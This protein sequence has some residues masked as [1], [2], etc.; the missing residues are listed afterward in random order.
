MLSN[1]PVIGRRVVHADARPR[2]AA[3]QTVKRHAGGLAEEV[4]LCH[5]DRAENPHVGAARAAHRHIEV[6]S[7]PQAIDVPRIAAEELARVILERADLSLIPRVSFA[8][9]DQARIRV[10]LDPAPLGALLAAAG[11]A[12]DLEVFAKGHGIDAGDLHRLGCIRRRLHRRRRFARCPAAATEPSPSCLRNV[13]R[14]V[15]LVCASSYVCNEMPAGLAQLR[16]GLYIERFGV[17]RRG[18][19]GEVVGA[20]GLEPRTFWV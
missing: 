13:L 8:G 2:L 4:H 17:L 19:R 7:A 9:A 6:E 16:L 5:V 18:G 20:R 11:P 12:A 14:L 10:Q 15:I 1:G 3:E